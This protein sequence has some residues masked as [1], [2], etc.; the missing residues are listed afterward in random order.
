MYKGS[1]GTKEGNGNYNIMSE[2]LTYEGI[3]YAMKM[4][5][6]YVPQ[7]FPTILIPLSEA[8]WRKHYPEYFEDSNV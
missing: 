6:K 8:H 5:K 4:T 3:M 2:I 1:E 7:A